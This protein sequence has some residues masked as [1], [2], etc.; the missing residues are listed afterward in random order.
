MKN[1]ELKDLLDSIRLTVKDDCLAGQT[2]TTYQLPKEAKTEKVLD[3][4]PEHFENYKKVEI[5][6]KGNLVLTHP[7]KE[8]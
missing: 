4:L 1:D 7:D 6:E 5:D 2:I 8:D 3:V